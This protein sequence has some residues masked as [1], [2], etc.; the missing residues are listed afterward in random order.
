[1]DLCLMIEGQEGVTWP[2]WEALARACEEHRIPELFRSDHYLNLDGIADRGSLD[3]WATLCGLAAV[4][5]T[6]RLG[7]MVSPATFRHPSLVAKMVT[8]ADHISGGRVELGLGAGWHE[9]EHDAYGFRFGS[10]RE[11]MDVFEEQLQV[12]LGNWGE[13]TFSFSGEHYELR[14]LDAQPKPIQRPHPPLIIGGGGG[15]RSAELAARFAD[16]YNTPFAAGDELRQR[17]QRV[18]QACERAGRDML[19]FS[20]MTGMVIGADEADLRD[21]AR[22]LSERRPDFEGLSD[23]PPGWIIGTIDQTAEQL[24]KLREAGVDR[25]MCQHLLHDDLDAVALIG[26]E[27]APKVRR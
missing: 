17:R 6:V 5:S 10:T 14:D 4:T 20:V 19:P 18:A 7:T 27:L 15:R 16:E 8:T 23:P 13:E 22:R 3:A 25:V 9:R 12:V 21:R 1:M 2:Q 26:E 11:R 24:V